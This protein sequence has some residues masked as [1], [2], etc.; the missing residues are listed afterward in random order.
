MPTRYVRFT[1]PQQGQVLH[2][3]VTPEGRVHVLSAAPWAGGRDT[4]EQLALE[5]LALQVP[6]DA[7][8]VVCVG[9][10]YRKH[11]EEMGK[12]VPVEP[13]IFLK[14]STALNPAGRAIRL[15]RV[16]EEVHYEAELAL[17]IGERVSGADEAQAQ[18]AIWGLTCFNAV[19]Y[20]HLTLPT[21]A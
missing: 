18:R 6:A 2:G 5:G 8:K 14:P 9:Q 3:R 20:T 17:V 12:P 21:K 11:A 19:S 4:G 16:S 10:N 13:L 15:P 1:H 7:S